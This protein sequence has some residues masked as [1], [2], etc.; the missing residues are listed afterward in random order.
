MSV[1]HRVM[2]LC[3]GNTDGIFEFFSETPCSLGQVSFGACWWAD[4]P[5]QPSPRHRK[6]RNDMDRLKTEMISRRREINQL[7]TILKLAIYPQVTLDYSS[8]RGV[9]GYGGGCYPFGTRLRPLAI[10]FTS[11]WH[12]IK[13]AGCKVGAA[14]VRKKKKRLLSLSANQVL[15]KP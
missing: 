6:S 9:W 5:T 7:L 3:L 15:I 14:C 4:D 2:L 13:P 10:I 11:V 1:G 12:E 8:P